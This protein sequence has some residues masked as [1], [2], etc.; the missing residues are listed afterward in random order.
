MS[1]QSPSGNW[2]GNGTPEDILRARLTAR[3]GGVGGQLSLNEQLALQNQLGGGG[4]GLQTQNYSQTPNHLQQ[5]PYTNQTFSQGLRQQQQQQLSLG[6]NAAGVG[7]T[8]TN[9]QQQQQQGLQYPGTAGYGK[10]N[11]LQNQSLGFV[12]PAIS[13]L[14]GGGNNLTAA[15]LANN[16]TN[17]SNAA[18]LAALQQQLISLQ[19]NA[20]QGGYQNT[21]QAS[22]ITNNLQQAMALAHQQQQSQN[23]R[24]TASFANNPNAL[25]AY[26]YRLQQQQ[27]Q[28]QNLAQVAARQSMGLAQQQQLTTTQY[29]SQ[30]AALHQA[31]QLHSHLQ[32]NQQQVSPNMAALLKTA[33]SGPPGHHQQPLG[34]NP[35]LS[36]MTHQSNQGLNLAGF[37]STGLAN[38][39]LASAPLLPILGTDLAKPSQKVIASN[40]SS[41]AFVSSTTA[42]Q[43]STSPDT[44][45]AQNPVDN[46]NSISTGMTGV[47][48]SVKN[49]PSVISPTAKQE[50]EARKALSRASLSSPVSGTT[51]QQPNLIPQS[52]GLQQGNSPSS[53]PQ[54]ERDLTTLKT[55]GQMLAK[56]GNTVES[57]VQNGL[58]GGCNAED[59]KIVWEA[60]VM[61]YASLKQYDSANKAFQKQG[62]ELVAKRA[63]SDDPV[64]TRLLM[65]AAKAPTA[66]VPGTLSE[67]LQCLGMDEYSKPPNLSAGKTGATVSAA[68]QPQVDHK[69]SAEAGEDEIDWDGIIENE[70]DYVPH[71]IIDEVNNKP[72]AEHPV[73]APDPRED[74]F[75]AMSYGFFAA[76]GDGNGLDDMTLEDKEYEDSALEEEVDGQEQTMQEPVEEKS[77]GELEENK[78]VLEDS[79]ILQ[80]VAFDGLNEHGM[81]VPSN[82]IPTAGGINEKGDGIVSSEDPIEKALNQGVNP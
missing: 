21:G 46:A 61:E 8:G 48:L 15:N 37:N 77:G 76:N 19:Q 71:T 62:A 63:K 11:Q 67:A 47:D 29:L 33:G 60:Y 69:T 72:T 35:M 28:Q 32:T 20:L 5:L 56:T 38:S 12:N 39:E 7:G 43:T 58:L 78:V 49:N 53:N 82:L 74:E 75:N 50:E 36:T 27:Q 31:N 52:Q 41:E 22:L 4:G 2:G 73:N 45:S 3:N 25:N 70:H 14:Q 34:D 64:A 18:V 42:L 1:W 26:L 16:P 57:A 59:V 81:H 24:N 40:P 13:G 54:K 65:E 80:P 30:Q 55:L 10:L 51:N 17:N 68:Q 23:L 6:L 44:T 79:A 66:S 9:F